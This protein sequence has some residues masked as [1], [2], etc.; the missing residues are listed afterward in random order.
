MQRTMQRLVIAALAPAGLASA[1]ARPASAVV[2]D[3]D[4]LSPRVE[5]SEPLK[6]E[7][8]H[9][10][11]CIGQRTLPSFDGQSGVEVVRALQ[12]IDQSIQ[13]N[14]APVP[15]SSMQAHIGASADGR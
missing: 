5:A 8:Q 13:N 14:G 7:C 9:F 4:I 2:R 15:V 1:G 3:G 6:V 10:L 12:A 11:D